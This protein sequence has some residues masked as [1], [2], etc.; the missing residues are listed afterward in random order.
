MRLLVYSDVHGNLP[1]FEAVLKDSGTVD[2]SI[3]LGDLVN[4]GPWSNECVD[5]ALSLTNTI[6]IRGNHEDAFLN[7]TYPGSNGLVQEFFNICV[8]DFERF[9]EIEKWG[10][11]YK[12]EDVNFCHT[13]GGQKIYEDTPVKLDRNWVI[14][15]S[16]HQFKLENNGYRLFN[17]GSVG[18]NRKYINVASYMLYDVGSNQ[19]IFK[20]VKY[21][22][23][24][25]IEKMKA[26]GYP[27]KCIG[28]Y[29]DKQRA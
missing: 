16:H 7:N 2:G 27:Q 26:S 8:Q 28:Y 25:V 1:A 5:L 23:D 21:N 22:V 20:N 12:R 29:S 17:P 18:Q 14:G 13:I 15:H 11:D 24:V 3:C 9:N 19:M 6:I 4:Y 10:Y